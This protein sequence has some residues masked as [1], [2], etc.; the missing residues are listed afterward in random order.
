MTLGMAH[1]VIRKDQEK[2]RTKDKERVVF[3]DL[4]CLRIDWD[5]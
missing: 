5:E 1:Y 4:S 2:E 3:S